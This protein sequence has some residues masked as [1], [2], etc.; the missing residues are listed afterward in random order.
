MMSTFFPCTR[1]EDRPQIFRANTRTNEQGVNTVF[2]VPAHPESQGKYLVFPIANARIIRV[3]PRGE[4]IYGW[5][6]SLIL[7][8][9]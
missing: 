2:H 1:T 9:V 8:G 4:M 5:E 7:F 6:N 3:R